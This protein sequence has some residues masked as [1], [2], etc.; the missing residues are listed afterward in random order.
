MTAPANM[1]RTD[2]RK[3]NVKMSMKWY[4]EA[5]DIRDDG[6]GT[7]SGYISAMGESFPFTAKLGEWANVEWL[8]DSDHNYKR[9]AHK[10]AQRYA[11]HRFVTERNRARAWLLKND[12]RLCKTYGIR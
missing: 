2:R 4:T 11:T 3:D 10:E 5:T 6:N 9:R 8:D 7:I 1:K 12:P